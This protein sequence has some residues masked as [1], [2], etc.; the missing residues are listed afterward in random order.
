MANRSR[1]GIVVTTD[2]GAAP[3]K[4]AENAALT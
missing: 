3:R 2:A 4:A 1:A